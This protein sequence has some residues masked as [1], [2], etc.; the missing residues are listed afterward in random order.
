MHR[1]AAVRFH[2][3]LTVF[4]EALNALQKRRWFSERGYAPKSGHQPHITR[5]PQRA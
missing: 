1:E 2:G 5:C 4:D 3:R